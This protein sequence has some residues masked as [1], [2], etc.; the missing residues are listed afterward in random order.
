[1]AV[2]RILNQAPQYLLSDGSV[3][4]GG[5][6][7]F[8]ETDLT[9]PKNTWSDEAMTTLNSNPVIMDAAGRTLTDVWG[10]GEYGVVMTDA[11]DVVQWTRNNV[12]AGG[13]PGV[14]IP[15]LVDGEFLTNNGSVL[16][17]AAI[18]QVPDPT[19]HADEMLFSDGTLA[20]W[21]PSPTPTIENT[22]TILRIGDSVI[23][24]GSDTAPASGTKTTSKAITFATAYT[25]APR[26]FVI[27]NTNIVTAGGFSPIPTVINK[28]AT[29][30]T[31]FFDINEEENT[32]SIT[33][34]VAFDWVAIGRIA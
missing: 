22:S 20:Y 12:Q 25:V 1:M 28:L 19:G 32:N 30:C 18:L 21:G 2:F 15:A 10:D 11:D 14:S 13:D 16:Q 27:S 34:P 29:G 8:Y 4:A 9:T 6:L 7:F 17:W 23:E 33:I 26:V 31:V 24:L 3:N 5:K